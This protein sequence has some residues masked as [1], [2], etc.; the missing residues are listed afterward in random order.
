MFS[1][2]QFKISQLRNHPQKVKDEPLKQS[3]KLT[4]FLVTLQ[5]SHFT[6]FQ[7]GHARIFLSFFSINMSDLL[8]FEQIMVADFLDLITLPC[9]HLAG[10][11]LHPQLS[12]KAH[13]VCLQCPSLWTTGLYQVQK[14]EEAAVALLVLA[15]G[16]QWQDSTR[17][18]PNSFLLSFIFSFCFLE[19][20]GLELGICYWIHML[21]ILSYPPLLSFVSTVLLCAV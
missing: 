9:S 6:I 11:L 20:F 2:F 7:S 16:K 18:S 4:C 3:H 17:W 12:Q 1:N 14:L 10:L 5:F 8:D 19:L 13:S 15:C 21:A